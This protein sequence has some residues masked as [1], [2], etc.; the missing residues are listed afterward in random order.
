MEDLLFHICP[1][2]N[3]WAVIGLTDK[4]LA[5]ATVIGLSFLK[6]QVSFQVKQAGE[7]A[8]YVANGTPEANGL[9]FRK[10]SDGLWFVKIPNDMINRE[11]IISAK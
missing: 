7:L 6:N 2:K 9:K 3:G 5:P 1:V 11:I 4:H 10:N 8:L